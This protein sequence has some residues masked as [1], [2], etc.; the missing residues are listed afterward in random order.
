V[1]VCYNNVWGTVCD[2]GWSRSDGIVACRQ[3]G[4]RFVSVTT[5]ARFGQGRGQI[6]LDNLLC[7][8]SETQL[9]RCRHNGFGRHDCGHSE[10]AGVICS[11]K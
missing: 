3:L 7:T 4:R 5:N 1:E 9:I 8:G 2:D 6:W 11:S 10:D